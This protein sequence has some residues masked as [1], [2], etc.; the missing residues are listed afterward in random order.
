MILN[1]IIS[2]QQIEKD[3]KKFLLYKKRRVKPCLIEK[4][5]IKNIRDDTN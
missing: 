2:S 1:G 3:V 5:N 4:I